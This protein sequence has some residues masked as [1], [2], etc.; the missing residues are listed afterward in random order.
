M[1]WGLPVPDPHAARSD[2]VVEDERP[3]VMLHRLHA[4]FD[5][6]TQKLKKFLERLERTVC[7]RGQSYKKLREKTVQGDVERRRMLTDYVVLS[8]IDRIN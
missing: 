4:V 3:Q 7:M 6:H 8:S 5:S 1:L 2:L